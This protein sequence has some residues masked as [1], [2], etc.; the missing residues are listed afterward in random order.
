MILA[1]SNLSSCIDDAFVDRADIK[2][3]IG[4]PGEQ[5]RYII[6]QD[7]IDVRNEQEYMK[8]QELSRVGVLK[9][10]VNWK[11]FT[12]LNEEYEEDRLLIS[13]VKESE[14]FSGRT[15]R[16]LPF[17][18]YSKWCCGREVTCNEFIYYMKRCIE[19]GKKDN[20]VIISKRNMIDLYYIKN[21]C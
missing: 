7:C 15:L 1:T 9:D 16:K 11:L 2:R 19:V 21:V 12:Q 13:L 4:N 20:E 8:N 3:F 5:G 18:T 6:L 17:T 14:G 10:N